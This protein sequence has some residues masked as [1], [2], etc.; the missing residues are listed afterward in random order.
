MPNESRRP[1]SAGEYGELLEPI[2]GQA[3]AYALSIM[4][5]RADAED[6]VQQAALLGLARLA[7]YDPTRSFKAWWFVVLRHCC[8]DVA[9]GRRFEALRA[10]VAGPADPDHVRRED[11]EAMALALERI[12]R[13]QAAILQLRYFAGLS[14]RE[15]AESLNLPEGT[16]MSRLHYA[17]KAL[18]AEMER[19]AS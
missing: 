17:R 11:W 8:L 15:I 16:V 13:E 3:A 4:R 12:P 14:Y 18:A 2:L 6:A 7:T 9:R 10:D 19:T 5:H 1:L